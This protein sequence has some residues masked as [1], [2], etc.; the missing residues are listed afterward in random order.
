M[1]RRAL[2]VGS[3]AG[4]SVAAMVLASA[5]WDVTIFE[6]GPNYFTDLASDRP[7][8]VFSNDELKMDRYFCRP[9]P[10]SEPRV[11]RSSPQAPPI[12]GAVQN[13]PQ[14]VGGGSVHWDAKTPRFWDIDFKKLSLLGPV[15]GANVADWPFDYAEIAPY[16]DRIEELIGVA[17]DV[18]LFP[19]EPTL[20]H[21]P[22]TKALPM[23]AG[24]PQYSSHLVAEG[25]SRVG[26]HPFVAPMAINSRRLRRAPR[27][28]QLRLLLGLRM[29]D[30]SPGGCAG[31]AA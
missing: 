21:A 14:T 18:H 3:G 16:Y 10:S 17:G 7:G 11:Y 20:A 26:L 12:I 22:R 24:P 27:L 19:K 15:R 28:Q 2:V 25:C 1:S 4:G 9:D 23:A 13:L 30:P 8:T 31:S 29:P 5:G 6:K